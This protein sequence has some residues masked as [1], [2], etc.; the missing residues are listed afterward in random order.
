MILDNIFTDFI[1]VI[2]FIW[3]R[4]HICFLR[5]SLME[6]C[7]KYGYVW[8][9]WHQFHTCTDTHKVCRIVKRSQVTALF[10]NRNY[11][12]VDDAGIGDLGSSVEYTVADSLYLVQAL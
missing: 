7:I 8:L 9:S 11:F 12:V 1:F 4:I 10:N 6:S 2:I 5:H 3:D